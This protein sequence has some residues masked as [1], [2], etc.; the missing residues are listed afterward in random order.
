MS[1]LFG[2]STE[3]LPAVLQVPGHSGGPEGSLGT[4][5]TGVDRRGP[6]AS[7][8]QMSVGIRGAGE[9]TGTASCRG[10]KAEIC[11]DAD[12]FFSPSPPG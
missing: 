5:W 1:E 11:A 4:D 3:T 9:V 6:T 7:Q 12:C 10:R 2:S 8:L